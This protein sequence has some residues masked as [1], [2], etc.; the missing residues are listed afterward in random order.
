MGSVIK[1]VVLALTLPINS[2][3]HIHGSFKIIKQYGLT[4]LKPACPNCHLPVE[5]RF[6]LFYCGDWYGFA[7]N[8]MHQVW[9]PKHIAILEGDLSRALPFILEDCYIFDLPKR[10]KVIVQ[11][12]YADIRPKVCNPESASILLSKE[13]TFNHLIIHLIYAFNF[14]TFNFEH[15]ISESSRR[16]SK[17]FCIQH[18]YG[19]VGV[20]HF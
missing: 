19:P 10:G 17:I 2:L 1:N 11:L 9:Q 20:K 16:I 4:S 3:E 5:T 12:V 8:V 7:A 14:Q 15:Y 13:H 18:C 6:S